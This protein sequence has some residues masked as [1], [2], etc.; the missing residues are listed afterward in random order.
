MQL[1][2]GAI[3]AG[4]GS[5]I[6]GSFLGMSFASIGWSVGSFIGGQL[7]GPQGQDIQG[8][9]L[10]DKSVSTSAYGNLRP[11][12]YGTYRVAGE[13]IWSTDLKERAH[14]E[15]AGKGGG[16]GGSYSTYTYTVSFAVAL[17]EGPIIG[18]RKIWL[19]NK[20]V[21]TQADDATKKELQKSD[22]LAKNIR[23]HLGT[24]TQE[25][26]STIEA[27]I[28]AGNVP[29]YRGT[30]YIVFDDLDVTTYGSRIPQVTVEVVGTG[31]VGFTENIPN[32]IPDAGIRQSLSI[33]N[34][35]ANASFWGYDY[36]GTLGSLLYFTQ[37]KFDLDG[38]VLSSTT[39]HA[40]EFAGSPY[41]ANG[42]RYMYPQSV[43]PNFKFA[44][45][46]VGDIGTGANLRFA[47]F[48]RN[49]GLLSYLDTVYLNSDNDAWRNGYDRSQNIKWLD[50]YTFYIY[51]DNSGEL[52]KYKIIFNPILGTYFIVR[53]WL[54]YV[55]PTLKGTDPSGIG[56]Q[57]GI[58]YST[59]EAYCV[60][61]ESHGGDVYIRRVSNDGEVI[62][63]K[64]HNAWGVNG[65]TAIG[66]SNGVLWI[67]T[68]YTLYAYEWDSAELLNSSSLTTAISNGL[69]Q[70]QLSGNLG[71]FLINGDI[72]TA[73]RTM[74]RTSIG[75]DDLVLDLCEKTNLDASDIDVTDLSSNVVRGYL[76]GSQLSARGCIQQLASTFFF[77]GVETDGQIKF[78]KRGGSIASTLSDDDIGCYEYGSNVEEL[79]TA[80]RTQE[81][82]LPQE[83]SLLY[84]QWDSDYQQGAQFSRREAVLSGNKVGVQ[85]SIALTD[86]EAKAIVDS[87]MFSAW[88]N[89]HQFKL[90]TWQKYAKLDPTDLIS[91]GGETIRIISRREGVNGLI[92]LE[93]VR[94]LPDIYSGQ[95]GT[96]AS[97]SVGGQVVHVGG[98]TLIEILDVQNL[99][100]KD[101]IT[102]GAYVAA[103]GV[104]D[105][106]GGMALLK[107]KDYG[108][109]WNLLVNS[110]NEATI[111][112]ATTILGDFSGGNIFDELNIVRVRVDGT[113]SS[114][115]WD[116]VLAGSNV[117][118]IGDE[119]LQ[120]RAATLIST[121]I[122]DLSG[123]LRGR[124][125][126]EWAMNTHDEYDRF[127][128]LDS[129]SIRFF[130][131][132]TDDYNTARNVGAVTL[133][134]TLDDIVT[135]DFTYQAKNRTPISP[136]H[137]RATKNFNGSL[138][139]GWVRRVAIDAEWI[140]AFDAG[141]DMP[142]AEYEV[143]IYSDSGFTT[144]VRSVTGLT[145]PDYTYSSADR[146]T[147][148]TS[149]SNYCYF[150]VRE[151]NGG[152]G[153]PYLSA[154]AQHSA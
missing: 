146:V 139:L 97:G 51:K 110:Y 75:L 114:A 149:S 69:W 141:L 48:V 11:V 45:A 17:C 8:P 113:L 50:D 133:G 25:P 16:G 96:G 108:N 92:E 15:E 44:I 118:L 129:S 67:T 55:E 83:L 54:C 58:D 134:D 136:I 9:R 41:E 76:I 84:S 81:E 79:L 62:E 145:S 124:K 74:T 23:F 30:A 104:F 46:E 39:A 2:L 52:Y 154:S 138:S 101:Y 125:G 59:G 6:P 140:D 119:I 100:D 38:T 142:S 49:G 102:Y 90:T 43:S 19:D 132:E 128:M 34:G 22:K 66:Y 10:T 89:R 57:F 63:S 35:L 88:H 7:F 27:D 82:E 109:N 150:K 105:D 116:E 137:G 103:R 68:I 64:F 13:I 126:T 115:T 94:E 5:L 31:A 14:K 21:Y 4:I 107:S 72:Y 143:Y 121:G 91:A 131:L 135:Q 99:R 70:F 29:A 28:G 18:V 98:P 53:E 77:D 112:Q 61:V 123:L 130:E 78:I 40:W 3:G 73:A 36:D 56:Y 148:G 12:V 87:M 117:C 120:F 24:T 60:C 33:V 153:S 95:V 147:D 111:G 151:M 42:C 80:T 65:N 26:D 106:W 47:V 85:I 20:L 93:G 127:I 32:T 1:A 86:D 152:L 37:K 144:L 122:Y 71:V